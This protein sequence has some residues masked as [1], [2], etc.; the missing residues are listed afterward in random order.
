MWGQDVPAFQEIVL[1]CGAIL[2][3]VE[4]V[5]RKAVEQ[6]IFRI[7]ACFSESEQCPPNQI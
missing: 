6:I 3:L 5:G 1:K 4:I 2:T 7:P